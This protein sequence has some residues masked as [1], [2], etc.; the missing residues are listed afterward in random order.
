MT[1]TP[2]TLLKF[3]DRQVSDARRLFE[4]LIAS[5]LL[6]VWIV[7]LPYLGMRTM[8]FH[9]P[10]QGMHS[11]RPSITATLVMAKAETIQTTIQTANDGV[12]PDSPNPANW[13]EEVRQEFH[14]LQDYAL[15]IDLF[16]IPPPTFYTFDQ[17]TKLPLPASEVDLN[18]REVS[19]LVA[20][21]K[22][23]L[24]LWID[25]SGGVIKIDVETTELPEDILITALE[26][27]KR[28]HFVPGERYGLRVPSIIRIEVS[29]DDGLSP[30]Y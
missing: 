13:V 28:T 15:G 14:P 7:L 29:Y 8:G 22:I 23:I 5:C 30:G 12:I 24:K 4:P 17:L 16:P 20:S 9:S 10:V 25:E 18:T 21:G 27:F 2:L 6:H 26:T 1:T 11:T 19:P 3:S